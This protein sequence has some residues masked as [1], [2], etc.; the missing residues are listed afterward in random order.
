MGLGPQN[1]KPTLGQSWIYSVYLGYRATR[2]IC[3][4]AYAKKNIAKAIRARPVLRW[5][6][7]EALVKTT[8]PLGDETADPDANAE[9]GL[10]LELEPEPE[11][12]LE[13]EG[14]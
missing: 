5:R 7:S 9:V 4:K 11:P 10:E 1:I 8:T 13:L 3:P 12:E 6:L 2:F 14:A